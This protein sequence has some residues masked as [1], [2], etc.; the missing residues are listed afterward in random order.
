M[1]LKDDAIET[2]VVAAVVGVGLWY[3]E[4]KMVGQVSAVGGAIESG[5]SSAWGAATTPIDLG[6]ATASQIGTDIVEAPANTLDALSFGGI[7]GASSGSS[8]IDAMKAGPFGGLIGFLSGDG[9]TNLIGPAPSAGIDYGTG[10]NDW[11]S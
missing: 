4:K 10:A 3:I 2:L 8:L 5:A 1:S 7:S 11:S 6:N 9:N